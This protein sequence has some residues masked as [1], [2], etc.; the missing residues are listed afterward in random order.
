VYEEE[1]RKTNSA[2]IN[3]STES[4]HV[5]FAKDALEG[6]FHGFEIEKRLVD[7]KDDQWGSGHVRYESAT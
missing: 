6:W 7:I 1:R 2:L 3:L 4:D 5:H